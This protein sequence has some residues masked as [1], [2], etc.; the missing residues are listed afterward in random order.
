MDNKEA[1]GHEGGSE[2]WWIGEVEREFAQSLKA[3]AWIF[4]NEENGRFEGSIRACQ[5]VTR[6]VLLRT[7]STELVYP[8]LQIAL[9]FAD[10]E[11]GGKPRLFSKK[12]AAIK[13]RERSP[14]RKQ[15]HRLAAAALEVLMELGAAPREA[16]DVVA[17]HVNRWPSMGAQEVKGATV[18]AW[19]RQQRERG[20]SEFKIVVLVMT[21]A[22]DPRAAVNDLLRNGPPGLFR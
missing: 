5:A 7:G 11:K 21:Q 6:F 9:A 3:A 17:R 19:R 2:R 4:E 8:F 12:T 22:P 15:I 18:S 14:E 10:L 20:G 1:P 16:A 13:E